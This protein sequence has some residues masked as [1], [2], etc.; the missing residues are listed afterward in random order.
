MT[1]AA[2]GKA[3]DLAELRVLQ[4]LAQFLGKVYT[5]G[6]IVLECQLQA[7]HRAGLYRAGSVGLPI[8]PLL[9]HRHA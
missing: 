1:K 3:F 9:I 7:G 4:L 6:R 2:D 5:A 8:E